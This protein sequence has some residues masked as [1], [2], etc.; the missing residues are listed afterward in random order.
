M[1]ARQWTAEQRAR[2]ATLIRGWQPWLAS[3][4]PSTEEGKRLVGTNAYKGAMR[5]KLRELG[6][7]LNDLF[8]VAHEK[9]EAIEQT[10]YNSAQ[11]IDLVTDASTTN[12]CQTELA[13]K[14]TS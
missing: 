12:L 11:N 5:P 10:S 1:A 6:R 2:Q 8:H 7:A 14:V 9:L 13:S 3:T 4:G